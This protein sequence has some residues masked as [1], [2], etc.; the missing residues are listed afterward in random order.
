[1]RINTKNQ[2]YQLKLSYPQGKVYCRVRAIGKFLGSNG[3]TTDKYTDWIYP[4]PD[5]ITISTS[6]EQDKNWQYVT[7]YAEDAK[8]KKVITYYDGT[9][10]SW[11]QKQN[12]TTK[13]EGS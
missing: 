11:W 12:T 6:F 10:R 1:V 9:L 2:Y 7:S 5:Y 3:E 13:E 8:H 4:S